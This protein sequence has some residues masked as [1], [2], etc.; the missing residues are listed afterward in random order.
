M[1]DVGTDVLAIMNLHARCRVNKSLPY[2]GGIL[3]QP[4]Y[5]MD[6]FDVID[7][8]RNA[9]RNAAAERENGAATQAQLS[10]ELNHG[11]R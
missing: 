8:V 6:L 11:K 7:S 1:P 9:Q 5:I 4:A 2:S 10:A 3:E